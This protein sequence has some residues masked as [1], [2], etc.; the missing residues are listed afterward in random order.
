MQAFLQQSIDFRDGFFVLQFADPGAR[1]VGFFVSNAVGDAGAADPD[2]EPFYGLE[3]G[4][5]DDC[6]VVVFV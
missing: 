6:L 4:P 1:E 2:V 3:D 5:V